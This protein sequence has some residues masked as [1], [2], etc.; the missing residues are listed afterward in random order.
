LRLLNT[1][2]NVS[3]AGVNALPGKA[4]YF[5][6]NDPKKWRT[7][8]STYARVRYQ[9]VYPGIDLIYYGNHAGQLEYDFVVAPGADPGAITLGVWPEGGRDSDFED[10]ESAGNSSLCIAEGGDLVIPGSSGN[11][12]IHRPIVYQEQGSE[13]KNEARNSKLEIRNSPMDDRQSGVFNRQSTISNRQFREGRFV[14]D[15]RNHVRFAL[16]PYDHTQ[17]LIIDPVLHYST[18]LGGNI[19]GDS[20]AIAVDSSGSAYVT[21]GAGSTDFPTSNPLQANLNGS[22]NCFVSK[23]SPDG[24]ALVYSTYLGGSNFDYCTGIAVDASGNAYVAGVTSSTDFPTVNPF[25]AT[26]KTGTPSSASVTAFVSKLNSAGLALIYST[27]LG[28]ST[29]DSASGIAVDA[30]GSA[31]VTGSTLSSDFPTFHAF[32]ATCNNCS[33]GDAFVTKFNPSGATLAYSTFLGGSSGSLANGI[34]V[35]AAGEAC[36]TGQ[37]RSYDFPTV[38]PLQPTNHSLE[39]NAFITKFN[40][41]GSA[42]VYST[43]LGG[44]YM[45]AGASIAVD[46]PSS[47]Y[48]TGSTYSTDFPTVDPFQSSP[49]SAGAAFVSKLNPSGSA[50]LYSTYLDGAT[51]SDSNVEISTTGAAIA[52]DPN[53]N[54]YV[55]GETAAVDFPTLNAIQPSCPDVSAG[56]GSAF[57]TEFNSAGTALVYST[58]LGGS[59]YSR[60]YGIAVD[61]ASNAYVTGENDATDFPGAP[62]PPP[63]PPGVVQTFVVKIAGSPEPGSALTLSTGLLTFVNQPIGMAS[64]VETVILRSVGAKSLNITNFSVSGDFVLVSTSSS[65]PYS[66]GTVA[67]GM[68]CS[69]DINFTPTES[70][71]R[72]GSIVITDNAGGSP[73]SVS[74][75]GVGLASYPNAVV[76][77]T[78]LAFASLWANNSSAPQPVTLSNTG[79]AALTVT[80]IAVTGMFNQTLTGLFNVTNNCGGSVAAG[81]S[82]TI[83]VTFEPSQ[84]GLQS[85]TLVITDDT[86]GHPNSTQ[87][88]NLSGV[89]ED[90]NLSWVGESPAGGNL[91]V[92]QTG[93]Y[94]WAVASVGGFNHS[95]AF[96]CSVTFWESLA[97]NLVPLNP[98]CTVSPTVI[99]PTGTPTNV[100][101]TVLMSEASGSALSKPSAPQRGIPAPKVVLIIAPLWAAAVWRLRSRRQ[102]G[103]YWRRVSL[104]LLAAGLLLVAGL[105]GC[106]AGNYG[107]GSNNQDCVLAHTG[108]SWLVTLKGTATAG[109]TTLTN[110]TGT[111]VYV[112]NP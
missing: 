60:G 52:V 83:N 66:G 77:P 40:A 44:S 16:G 30:S 29:Q 53:G 105:A 82:C 72:T 27:Y 62:P 7:N 28:G 13:A 109:S 10:R 75:A 58:Y 25:Q 43:Y 48:V 4:N 85:A 41:A 46:S 69:I 8:I 18:N 9:D 50:L 56:C 15:A 6:G 73:Q 20:G 32:Q 88:V 95:V 93:V 21:G 86:D 22:L 65:C 92:G 63:S 96:S 101:V 78:T 3:V 42:L 17:P 81:A 106:G 26:N 2:P 79:N 57:V 55:T 1:N 98:T 99:T 68:Y 87:S 14:L 31:Y 108:S 100:A 39:G 33:F 97:T 71:T 103:P 45:D 67:S 112:P 24:S 49:N 5:I 104:V 91:S 51:G 70:G 64:N 74:L 12:R 111:E 54:A 59:S 47:V 84:G 34:A 19:S 80:S 94:T 89:C 36:L 37:T 23:L 38:N 11:V 110:S 102:T 76:S 107:C 90:F 35:D 61:S